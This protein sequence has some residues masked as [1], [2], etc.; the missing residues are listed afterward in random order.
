MLRSTLQVGLFA[1]VLCLAA[2]EASAFGHHGWGGGGC[3]WGGCGGY[4]GG[5]GGCGAGGCGYGGGWY[6]GYGGYNGYGYG[7]S[8][9]GGW[10]SS[11]RSSLGYLANGAATTA[12]AQ[13]AGA[14]NSA[15]L[16]VSVPADAKVFVNDRETTSTGADRRFISRDL[17]S[18]A[19]YTYRVR[20]EFIRNGQP[21]SEEQTVKLIAGQNQSLAFGSEQVPTPSATASLK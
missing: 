10:G 12:N 20:A 19:R 18:N 15:I 11:P 16:T 5:W 14:S 6:G 13:V 8:W 7:G 9:Y 17:Q 1:V 4:G 2:S 3:G 21:V